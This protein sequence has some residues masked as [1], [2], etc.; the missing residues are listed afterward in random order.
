MSVEKSSFDSF[1]VLQDVGTHSLDG[2]VFEA[3]EV[4]GDIQTLLI[5]F[6]KDIFSDSYITQGGCESVQT[7]LMNEEN[8]EQ[9]VTGVYQSDLLGGD[10]SEEDLSFSGEEYASSIHPSHMFQDVYTVSPVDLN[11]RQGA[12]APPPLTG[13]HDDPDSAVIAGEETSF[14]PQADSPSLSVE[15]VQ[16]MED[17]AIALHIEA[18]LNDQDGQETLHIQISNV[19]E[20]GILSAGSDQGHGLWILSA[21]DLDDLSLSMPAHYSGDFSLN[22]SAVSTEMTGETATQTLSLSVV[23]DPVVDAPHMSVT[24][25]SGREDSAIALDIQASLVDQDGSE[26]LS[27]VTLSNI[28]DGAIVSA[29][30]EN[31]DGSYDLTLSDLET[32]TITPPLH[33]N[34]DFTLSL[35]VTSTESDGQSLTTTVPLEVHVTGVADHPIATAQFGGMHTIGQGQITA[36]NARSTD[37][38]FQVLAR[39]VNEDGTLTNADLDY[40]GVQGDQGFGAGGDTDN[41]WIDAETGYD[42]NVGVSEELIL[43]FD[44][45]IVNAKAQFSYFFQDWTGGI[46]NGTVTAYRDGQEVGHIDFTAPDDQTLNINF[47]DQAFNKLIFKAHPYS[48]VEDINP[49]FIP[50]DSSDFLMQSFSYMKMAEIPLDT[51]ITQEDTSIEIGHGLS[52]ELIDTDGSEVLGYVIENIPDGAQLS[53]GLENGDGTYSLT[54]DELS[55]LTF[56]PPPNMSGTISLTFTV[57]TTEN[58]GDQAFDSVPFNIQIEAVADTPLLELRT[59][60]GFEDQA[61]DLDISGDLT[62]T[63]GSETLSFVLSRIPEGAVLTAGDLNQDGSYTLSS[64]DLEGLQIVPPPNSNEDI[65]LKVDAISTEENGDTAHTVQYQAVKITGVADTP[66]VS[67]EDTSGA[68][69]QA[70]SLDISV[71]SG[72]QDGSETWVYEITEVPDGAQFSAGVS[73]GDGVWQF[74]AEDLAYLSFIAPEHFSGEINMALSALATE[75]DGDTALTTEN[76]SVHVEAVADQAEITATSFG[77]EDQDISVNIDVGLVDQDGSE[78]I[79]GI[80]LSDIPEGVVFSHGD[81]NSTGDLRLT[82]AD[83]ENLTLRTPHNSNQDFHLKV[84][85]ETTD[86]NGDTALNTQSFKV[87]VKGVAD[88]PNVYAQDTLGIEDTP[89]DMDFGG[90]LND[91]DGSERL[92]FDV[93]DI[94]EGGSFTTGRAIGRGRHWRFNNEAQAEDAQLIPPENFSGELNL[95]FRAY[96]RENDGN[97]VFSETEFKVSVSGVADT[98]RSFSVREARGFEDNE[99]KLYIRHS[100]AD[101]DGSEQFSVVISDIPEG[102]EFSHGSDT[103]DGSWVV[104]EEDISALTIT[105][106][107]NSNEDFTLS[108]TGVVTESDGDIFTFETSLDLPVF[109]RGVADRPELD[110]SD[111]VGYEDTPLDLELGA[112]LTDLDGS[113]NLSVVISNIPDGVVLSPSGTYISAGTYSYSAQDAQHITLIPPT[114]FSGEILL[115]IRAVAQENDGDRDVFNTQLSVEIEAIADAPHISG[116]ASGL[117]DTALSLDININTTDSDGSETIGNSIL[118]E[119]IPEGA[120]LSAGINNGDGSYLLTQ[121]ELLNLKITPP[122]HSNENF[123]LRVTATAVDINGDTQNSTQAL[124]VNITGDADAPELTVSDTSALG[125]HDIP[126]DIHGSMVDTDASE[127]LYYILSE[128][129]EIYQVSHGIYGGSGRWIVQAEDIENVSLNP[130]TYDPAEFQIQVTAVTV[131]N[132]GDIA[133]T[134]LPLTVQIMAV[135]GDGGLPPMPEISDAPSFSRTIGDSTDEDTQID[136]DGTVYYSDGGQLS[137]LI[138]DI[139]EGVEPNLGFYDLEG[140]LIVPLEQIGDLRFEPVDD[141]AGDLQ[142]T[143]TAIQIQSGLLPNSATKVADIH[144]EAVA[145]APLI[146][147]SPMSGEEDTQISIPI[148]VLTSDQDGSEFITE[149]VT[150]ENVPEGAFLSDGLDHG[151]GVWM[152]PIS[153]L[154]GLTFTPPAHAHGTYELTLTATSEETSNSDQ[155]HSSQTIRVTVNAVADQAT[156]EISAEQG[157]E[158]QWMDLNINTH[159]VDQDGSESMSIILS[160][161]PEEARLSAGLNNGDGSWTLQPEDTTGLQIHAPDDFAG[162]IEAQV[163]VNTIEANGNVAITSQALSLNFEGVSDGVTL[164]ATTAYIGQ[165]D[166][167]IPI[168]LNADTLDRD[169]SET[170]EV[171]FSSFP[172]GSSFSL[173]ALLEDGRWMITGESIN[174]AHFIPPEHFSGEIELNVHVDS[175]D[176]GGD[177]SGVDLTQILS[178]TA[179]ADTPQLDIQT[180]EYEAQSGEIILLE[181]STGLTDQDGS[182]HLSVNISDV[183][184][185][186]SFSAGENQGQGVWLFEDVSLESLELH[187]QENFT[188][189]FTLTL[190]ATATEILNGDSSSSDEFEL[191][192]LLNP[193]PSLETRSTESSSNSSENWLDS[194]EDTQGEEY[195]QE[196][197]ELEVDVNPS[198]NE[199][200]ESNVSQDSLSDG[201]LFS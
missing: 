103:V 102:T 114:D 98:P 160:G 135:S 47:M 118:I 120:E 179:I 156:L 149:T 9:D 56:T 185:E 67:I 86:E 45:L 70:I 161:L 61:I 81:L 125:G 3:F 17:T 91:L 37:Q 152:V 194:V 116:G 26:T 183:P 44:D 32:L 4:G 21:Q 158:D 192:F 40:V 10:Y 50:M 104:L 29:G 85:V 68:E 154:A 150:I 165:E 88:K 171:I 83:L 19:P 188:G 145:D 148:S 170:L 43:Q 109:V 177:R 189:D 48:N 90:A 191:F 89:I 134:N 52:G 168:I 182:E 107:P 126:L 130:L 121:D 76:F 128:V 36:E 71:G 144:L 113:E 80:T 38:G 28:P 65:I 105:P 146:H 53:A 82:Q 58:D 187:T 13:T 164:D 142:M 93:R 97:R 198:L 18:A 167:A 139:P 55:Q 42:P 57:I 176:S 51:I 31:P 39:N 169:G 35:S 153:A 100:L 27:L 180:T 136:V 137:F 129:P 112:Y 166:H 127:M 12:D 92:Y 73:Q 186:V 60:R 101:Q 163:T 25:A 117:E 143:Y 77:Y 138:T 41:A 64:E 133:H 23:I 151:N 123:T 193:P 111:R 131:E 75:N 132:D 34:E 181:I 8:F 30:T 79:T 162:L 200:L 106:P 54:E 157:M 94:P 95:T 122:E 33:S 190:Q 199:G 5:G 74:S 24:S 22:V 78:S 140:G 155:A 84:S 173:G 141:F 46:E 115:D 159:F 124:T 175:I 87:D 7:Y 72:D 197:N 14:I 6:D 196:N 63:D 49:R 16:G 178:I 174:Q 119:H 2:R 1:T 69:D 11:T 96:A 147:V 110:L 62:D 201:G 59:A 108:V 99:I 66:T 195:R 172:E 184:D 15:L 20:G